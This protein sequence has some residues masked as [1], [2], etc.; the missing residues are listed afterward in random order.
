MTSND[1]GYNGWTNYETWCVGL[2]INN[3]QGWQEMTHDRLREAVGEVVV[4]DQGYEERDV[5]L[6]DWEAGAI[7]R[8]LVE[9]TIDPDPDGASTTAGLGHDLLGHA[10]DR[11]NWSELGASFLQDIAEQ[12]DQS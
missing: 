8:E 10:L 5:P 11:V 2:W 1:V 12:D 6:L 9:E 3:D 7:V 4:G